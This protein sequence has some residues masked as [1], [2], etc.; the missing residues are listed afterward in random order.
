[1][2][3]G[4]VGLDSHVEKLSGGGITS[5]VNTVD[6]LSGEGGGRIKD[7]S[8]KIHIGIKMALSC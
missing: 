4:N 7:R 1:M 2:W 6:S 5:N 3:F 8:V